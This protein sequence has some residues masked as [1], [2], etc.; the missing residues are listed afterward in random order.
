MRKLADRVGAETG[1]A[2]F[3]VAEVGGDRAN[4][5][6]KLYTEGHDRLHSAYGFLYLYADRLTPELVAE[7]LG[8]W[9]DA[10]GIGWPISSMT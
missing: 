10:P 3:L 5:E 8:E 6:M 7:A 1:R 2:R 4:E 9:P